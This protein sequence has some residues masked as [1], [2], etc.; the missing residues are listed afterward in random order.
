MISPRDAR[1]AGCALVLLAGGVVANIAYLQGGPRERRKPFIPVGVHVPPTSAKVSGDARRS[2]GPVTLSLASLMEGAQGEPQ[3]ESAAAAP[4]PAAPAPARSSGIAQLINQLEG[5]QTPAASPE[6]TREQ[7]R[8]AQTALAAR[9]YE[10][11]PADGDAGLMTRAAIMAFE[12][13]YGLPVTAE[14][15]DALLAAL[16][17]PTPVRRPAGV[18]RPAPSSTAAGIVR[19]AQQHLIAAGY[20]SGT[21]NAQLDDRTIAAIRAFE[22]GNDLMPTGRISAPFMAKLQR[23]GVRRATVASGR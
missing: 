2:G 6:R 21:A 19:T 13:D 10:P 5:A 8:E 1:I 20:L 18:S 22:T 12:H 9:N 4:L 16:R 7:V 14:V 3:R 23:A 15:T 17:S 11:G